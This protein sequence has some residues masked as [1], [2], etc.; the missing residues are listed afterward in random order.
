LRVTREGSGELAATVML[1]DSLFSR[2][3]GL[4]ARQ[5]PE[6]ADG[7]LLRP[8]LSVHTAFMRYPIDVVYLN[9]D[10]SIVKIVNEL[11]P[12]R[13]S[14]GGRRARQALELRA[15]RASELGLQVGQ[16]LDCGG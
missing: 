1:A 14:W 16:T 15:R 12:W 10:G 2:A 3:R 4:L 6:R 7:L 11:R 8:C 5:E 13:V 9:A